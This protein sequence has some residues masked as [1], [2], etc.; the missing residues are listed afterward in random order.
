MYN[1]RKFHSSYISLTFFILFICLPVTLNS[2]EQIGTMQEKFLKLL[3]FTGENVGD[4]VQPVISIPVIYYGIYSLFEKWKQIIAGSK[5]GE[6]YKKILTLGDPELKGTT[7]NYI[8]P[9]IGLIMMP[10]VDSLKSF[11]FFFQ[12][13]NF[14]KKLLLEKNKK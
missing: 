6:T 3:S 4:K 13:S 2:S 5:L 12:V 14:A 10:K 8:V 9:G 11:E 7:L 1:G